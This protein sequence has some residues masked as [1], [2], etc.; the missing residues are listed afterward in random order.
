MIYA[1]ILDD[2]EVDFSPDSFK[3]SLE[4]MNIGLV[5]LFFTSED[6]VPH[7]LADLDAAPADSL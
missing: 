7:E 4:G 6:H 5:E 2:L 1:C 3:L